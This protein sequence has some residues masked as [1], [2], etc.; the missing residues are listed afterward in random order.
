M[1]TGTK[2][3]EGKYAHIVIEDEGRGQT[4]NFIPR[5]DNIVESHVHAHTQLSESNDFQLTMKAENKKDLAHDD[6]QKLRETK[7]NIKYS[8]I[9][10]EGA[11]R[12]DN[13]GFLSHLEYLEQQEYLVTESSNKTIKSCDF[14]TENSSVIA[15]I[16]EDN[17][18][19]NIVLS[20]VESCLVRNNEEDVKN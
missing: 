15:G 7:K 5:E 3:E 13:E 11:E 2:N 18:S 16:V 10:I 17:P 12:N 20:E 8:S 9:I 19:Y 4:L 14:K 1:Y 6:D